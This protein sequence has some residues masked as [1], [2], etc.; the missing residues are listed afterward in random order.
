MPNS[1][2]SLCVFCGAHSGTNPRFA[3]VA[4]DLGRYLA[5]NKIRLVTGGGSVGLMGAV[6][7]GCLEAGGEVVGVIT[8]YLRERELA[9]P[10]ATVMEVTPNMLERKKRMAELSEGFISLPGGI[11]TLD[12][13]FEMLTWS[14]LSEHDKPSGLLNVDGFYDE[15]ISFC[16]VTQ[17]EAGFITEEDAGNLVAADSIDDLIEKLSEAARLGPSSLYRK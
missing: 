9:H 17:V 8:T 12:E 16:T 7:D 1:F 14:R 4:R 13:L 15:L 6:A 11:G 2:Q 3:E 5:E 10:K